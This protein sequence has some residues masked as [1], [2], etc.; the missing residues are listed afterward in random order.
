MRGE[1]VITHLHRFQALGRLAG[2]QDDPRHIESSAAEGAL[3]FSCVALRHVYVGNDCAT[4]AELQRCATPPE[5]REQFPAHADRGGSR[6]K[7]HGDV[8]HSRENTGAVRR[9]K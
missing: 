3:R 8:T 1:A 2:W 4:V 6:A 9:V 7:W 5:L